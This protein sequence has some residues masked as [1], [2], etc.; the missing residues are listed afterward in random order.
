M[1]YF[2][3]T[4]SEITDKAET[5]SIA[6]ELALAL[7]NE[8][9]SHFFATSNG[10]SGPRA[11]HSVYVKGKHPLTVISNVRSFA[12]NYLTNQALTVAS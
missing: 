9:K 7:G 1:N 12:K 5:S 10:V 6:R 4:Q 3:S 2:P 8:F 11:K